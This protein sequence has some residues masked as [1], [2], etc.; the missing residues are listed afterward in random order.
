MTDLLV[1]GSDG[2]LGRA[3]LAEAAARGISAEGHDADTLDICDA[4]AVREMV[5]WI[6]PVVLINAAAFT[7]VDDCEAREDEAM[8]INGT[9]VGNLAAACDL[10]GTVLV[11]ISTDYVFSGEADRPYREDDSPAPINA[12]GRTKLRGEE[13]AASAREHL[14]VRTA[15]LYGLGG[16]SFVEAIR[17]QIGAGAARLQVVDDQ[18]GSPTF[19]GD[20]AAA[21]LDLLEHGARGIVHAVNAGSTT[22]FGFAREIAAQLGADVE[23]VPVRTGDVPRA[24]ARP[25][26]SVL[27]T[28]RL[29]SLLGHPMPRWPDALA[30]YLEASC[31]S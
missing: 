11:Q 31:A 23:V 18:R 3:L 25:P 16:R 29:A 28:R 4:G 26:S 5:G 15:W 2:Q 20:L 8:A 9:A 7:A 21:I 14:I 13:M 6:R 24:A 27:D 1:T 30:R 12:Y 19:A 17:R 10:T 22:W